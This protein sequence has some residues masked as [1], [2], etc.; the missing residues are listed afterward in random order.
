MFNHVTL[1][2]H[3]SEETLT[4]EAASALTQATTKLANSPINFYF[5]T[6]DRLKLK[7]IGPYRDDGEVLG[8][9][10]LGVVSAAEFY[11]RSIISDLIH[12]CP[13]CQI[14]SE[15]ITVPNGAYGYY[16]KSG[17]SYA[18]AA[19]EHESLAD[20]K[21][22]AAEFKRFSGFALLEDS[23]VKKALD[24]FEML[25]ELRHCFIH[26]QGYAGLKASRALKSPVRKLQSISIDHIH[27]LELIKISH[28]TVRATNKFIANSVLNRWIDKNTLIGNWTKD[29]V[30][31]SKY[32]ELFYKKEIGI[33]STSSENLYKSKIA[34]ILKKRNQAAVGKTSRYS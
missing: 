17:F 5:E 32:F 11:F 21:K 2:L 13:L 12:L 30:I 24:D 23:S 29:K 20:S 14:Q 16:E 4:Y 22:L 26:A 6:A 34:D 28:N 25:C 19:F 8:L 27:A 15:M 31:F 1:T 33:E 18:M 3:N 10:V 9:L 7:I